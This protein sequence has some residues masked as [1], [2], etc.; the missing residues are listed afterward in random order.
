M[1]CCDFE[2]L[3][4]LLDKQLDLDGKIEVLCHLDT[5]AICREAIYQISRERDVGLFVPPPS[6]A[7]GVLGR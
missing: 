5:C 1:K 6:H 7:H 3:V 4:R 2:T